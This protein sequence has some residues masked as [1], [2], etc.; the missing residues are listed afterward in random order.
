MSEVH[1]ANY[2]HEQSGQT[3]HSRDDEDDERLLLVLSQHVVDRSHSDVLLE[4]VGNLA[5]QELSNL[6]PS[7]W[8]S[9]LRPVEFV[10]P[11]L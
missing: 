11:L 9:R 2:A 7:Q 8:V 6:L 4:L 5:Y 3:N 1:C 10:F